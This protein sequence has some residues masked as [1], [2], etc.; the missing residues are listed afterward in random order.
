M[1]LIAICS[2]KHPCQNV[3]LHSLI[4]SNNHS[5]L[6]PHTPTEYRHFLGSYGSSQGDLFEI[7]RQLILNVS[8]PSL[9]KYFKVNT[10]IIYLFVNRY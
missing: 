4:F 7:V 5:D 9:K 8:K 3:D 1:V 6:F 2:L 10:C